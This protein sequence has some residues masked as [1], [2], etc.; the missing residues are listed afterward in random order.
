MYSKGL[1]FFIIISLFISCSDRN[2]RSI[3]DRLQSV[4]DKKITKY[5]ARGVSAS[6]V[7]PDGKVWTGTSGISHDTVRIKPDML[8]AIGSVT[9]NVVS[10]LILKLDEE[11]ILSIEDPLSRWLPDYP[12]INNK[13]TIRQLL[14]HTSGIY[15]FW[16]NQKIW[17]DLKKDRTKSWTPEEVLSYIKEPD[18]EAGEG[19]R[20]SNT[21]YLLLGMILEKATSSDLSTLFRK[22]F[23]KS[24]QI[25]NVYVMEMDNVPNNLAHVYGDNF[26]FGNEET[27]LTFEPRTSH[28]T[29]AF[30]SSGIFTTA[31]SLAQWS[32]ALFEGEVLNEQSMK[33]MLQFVEFNPVS[34]MR[35][36]G[37]GVQ[38][39]EKRFSHG[40]KA[41]GHGGGNIG[42][43]TY[44]VFL[45]DYHISIVVMVNAFPNKTAD[46]ITKALIKETLK[47]VNAIGIIPY[48]EF[49]PTGILI[50]CI[51]SGLS[52]ITYSIYK[53][54][55]IT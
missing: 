41:I 18:F 39:F 8:F 21:N 13:I 16:E 28:E 47:E 29:I 3:E 5:G 26:V 35:A 45:P 55:S 52:M 1:S 51:V 7:F 17:D 46:V 4:L 22:Y 23:W 33:E 20:Y 14:N 11:G 53:K 44:M 2:Q 6:V 24:L 27:D 15:M 30:A 54:R 50:I 42:T 12:F 19:W 34:N 48:I 49:F 43:T 40:K 9:K 38:L 10:A 36:Y 25:D 31:E 37:L 32:H